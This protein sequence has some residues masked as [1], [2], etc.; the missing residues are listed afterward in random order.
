MP[1]GN[2]IVLLQK[3][4]KRINYVSPEYRS[5]ILTE[6]AR[7][8]STVNNLAREMRSSESKMT[9]GDITTERFGDIDGG[10]D[11]GGFA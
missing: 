9:D 2:L 5:A 1:I 8:L 4:A 11:S 3:I 10:D 6:A 7:R